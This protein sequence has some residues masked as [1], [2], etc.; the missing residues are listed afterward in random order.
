MSC[1]PGDDLGG[2]PPRKGRGMVIPDALGSQ[3]RHTVTTSYHNDEIQI[4]GSYACRG[5]KKTGCVASGR[6]SWPLQECCLR[7]YSANSF[8]L[9]Y[10]L[11]LPPIHLLRLSTHDKSQTLSL[12]T[13]TSLIVWRE[14]QPDA[15]PSIKS[16]LCSINASS[17]WDHLK[18][19]TT[20]QSGSSNGLSKRLVRGVSTWSPDP[21][22]PKNYRTW[23]PNYFPTPR[24]LTRY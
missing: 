2:G 6:I 7:S 12:D 11:T 22:R 5:R 1:M 15:G 13:S 3:S 17:G 19:Y 10:T 9:S 24:T 8:M 4:N 14:C 18:D 20:I 23:L 21:L 16:L